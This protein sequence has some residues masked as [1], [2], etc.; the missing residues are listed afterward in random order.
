MNAT[1]VSQQRYPLG[2]ALYGRLLAS[3]PV[4]VA[5][6]IG[7]VRMFVARNAPPAEVV[8]AVG[9]LLGAVGGSTVAGAALFHQARPSP[10]PPVGEALVWR[11]TLATS[12]GAVVTAI[13]A[14]M[15]GVAVAT[16]GL[17]PGP[18]SAGPGPL[19]V[20]FVMTFGSLFLWF[21]SSRIPIAR[22]EADR[23]GI[24]CT[25]PLTTVRI[26]WSDLRSLEVRGRSASTNGSW[27]SPSRDVSE[28]FG[29]GILGSRSP[30]MS[31]GLSS[32][33]WKRFGGRRRRL[34]GKEWSRA[35]LPTAS[36]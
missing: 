17:T 2:V 8:G 7:V 5:V 11:P 10:R 34:A 13:G 32:P 33:N 18:F 26:P 6:A 14:G 16:F 4:L 25:T 27:R 19:L 15:A 9:A 23:W 35:L 28:Y 12:A 20:W 31:H 36:G 24:R 22:L 30:A 29:S 21:V 1:P 3:G